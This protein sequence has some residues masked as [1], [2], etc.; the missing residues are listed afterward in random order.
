M[1]NNGIPK[2]ITKVLKQIKKKKEEIKRDYESKI[3]K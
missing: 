3:K 1:M 2:R